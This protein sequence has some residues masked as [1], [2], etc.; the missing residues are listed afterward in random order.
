MPV[1]RRSIWTSGDILSRRATSLRDGGLR[2]AV[3]HGGNDLLALFRFRIRVQRVARDDGC[4]RAIAPCDDPAA[5]RGTGLGV[6]RAE[7]GPACSGCGYRAW[8]GTRDGPP[9]LHCLRARARLVARP[10][11]PQNTCVPLGVRECV[12]SNHR[13]VP[14][15][16]D[17]TVSVDVDEGENLPKTRVHHEPASFVRCNIFRR[18]SCGCQFRPDPTLS[19]SNRCCIFS[20]AGKFERAWL[21]RKVNSSTSQG[22]IR[23]RSLL[24]VMAARVRRDK[25][26]LRSGEGLAQRACNHSAE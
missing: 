18:L 1:L 23:G 14:L 2:T 15:G 6:V 26:R 11:P 25:V 7:P 3:E 21:W 10:R 20:V 12:V 16:F 17:T 19:P 22:S 13:S 5:I 8:L 4:P 24:P 9:A